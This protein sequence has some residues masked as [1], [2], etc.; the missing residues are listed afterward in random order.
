[1]GGVSAKLKVQ[2]RSIFGSETNLETQRVQTYTQLG[3]NWIVLLFFQ[4]CS[5]PI[6]L[7]T[8]SV[9]LSL[10]SDGNEVMNM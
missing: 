7:V 3:E 10:S 9:L 4:G 5:T 2:N 1:M 8:A 6:N